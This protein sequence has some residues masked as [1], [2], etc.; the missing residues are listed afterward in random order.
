MK[1]M[2]T[3]NIETD[4]D[5]TNG[6]RGEIIDIILHPDE[7]PIVDAPV[8]HLKYMP[9]Y[10][11]VKLS[12]TRATALEGLEA[13]VIPI[14]PV[15][16]SYQIKIQRDGKLTQKTVRRCQYPMTAAYAF[17]DY[18]SQG[19]TLPYVI[20]DIGSPPTGTLSL[21]NLYVAL[22]RSSGWDTIRLL[23]DFKDDLFRISHD[24]ALTAEDERLEN[25]DKTTQK[26]YQ[27][28]FP[29]QA[30]GLENF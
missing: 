7:L 2:V 17:T 13:N 8:V 23:R 27:R 6:A 14:E 21:F 29:R 4:L 5:L 15:T 1:V 24:P 19:Q 25:L 3:E 12:R 20:V 18:R 11:L 30:L 9:A 26:W 22:S 28:V 10:I 16:T